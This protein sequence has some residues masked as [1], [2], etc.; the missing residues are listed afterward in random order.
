MRFYGRGAV[1]NLFPI[2]KVF[3]DFIGSSTECAAIFIFDSFKAQIRPH[4]HARNYIHT[5]AVSSIL[6]GVAV[7]VGTDH[8]VI[9]QEPVQCMIFARKVDRHIVTVKHKI[10]AECHARTGFA[11]NVPCL[12]SSFDLLRRP[13]IHKIVGKTYNNIFIEF[14]I[15]GIRRTILIICVCQTD[16]FYVGVDLDRAFVNDLVKFGITAAYITER[17]VPISLACFVRFFGGGA[18]RLI[19]ADTVPGKTFIANALAGRVIFAHKN[20]GFFG[21]AA[22]FPVIDDHICKFRTAYAHTDQIGSASEIESITAARAIRE[23]VEHLRRGLEKTFMVFTHTV[24]V[25]GGYFPRKTVP[26]LKNDFAF[27]KICIVSFVFPTGK[28]DKSFAVARTFQRLHKSYIQLGQHDLA[29]FGNDFAEFARKDP[30]H[31]QL[32]IQKMRYA[33]AGSGFSAVVFP[34]TFYIA[35]DNDHF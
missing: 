28:S 7:K 29:L 22:R 2:L 23:H 31:S 18:A 27:M 12:F 16:N 35:P 3:F 21:A 13:R 26:V 33:H 34:V 24:L 30:A 15:R 20:V 6:T 5:K 11:P 9:A 19:V 25:A 1:G 10:G 4:G 8:A 17:F 14:V 32:C